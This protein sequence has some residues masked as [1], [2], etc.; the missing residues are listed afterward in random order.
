MESQFITVLIDY[1]LAGFFIGYLIWVSLRNEKKTTHLQCKYEERLDSIR[2][3]ARE[4]EESSLLAQEKLRERYEGVVAK[5]DDQISTYAEERRAQID[6]YS[7][8]R[9]ESRRINNEIRA[10]LDAT[11]DD[12]KKEVASN[13]TQIARLHEQ[14]S[15]LM[16]GT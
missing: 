7:V 8:E 15:L 14:V 10:K 12:I 16:R 11:L 2:A 3:E 6:T 9:E 5:Y 13:G 1:G 4:R